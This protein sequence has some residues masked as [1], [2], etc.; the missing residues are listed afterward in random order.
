MVSCHPLY[1]FFLI[2][3]LSR[4]LN[5][6]FSFA[7]METTAQFP[8]LQGIPACVAIQGKVYH[9]VRPQHADSAIHWILYDGFMQNVPA[10]QEIASTLPAEWVASLQA[11]LLNYNPFVQHLRQLSHLPPDQCLNTSLVIYDRCE[12]GTAVSWWQD[13]T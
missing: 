3:L 12:C 1:F 6:V 11:A 13:R 7:S 2:T 9:R 5:L 10:H 8:N 4:R